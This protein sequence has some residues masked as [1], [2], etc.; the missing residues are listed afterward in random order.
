MEFFSITTK[1]YEGEVVNF[2]NKLW[3][4]RN[5]YIIGI[6]KNLFFYLI[7]LNHSALIVEEKLLD[8]FSHHLD[9]FPSRSYNSNFQN[10]NNYSDLLKQL[11]NKYDD[12]YE[13]Y[14]SKLIKISNQNDVIVTYF[15]KQ[16][17]P[18][19]ECLNWKIYNGISESYKIEQYYVNEHKKLVSKNKPKYQLDSD[20][21]NIPNFNELDLIDECNKTHKPGF[22][23]ESINNIFSF[24]DLEENLED[25]THS[26]KN[27]ELNDKRKKILIYNII[28]NKLRN[29]GLDIIVDKI[30]DFVEPTINLN[31]GDIVLS[32]I[33]GV[34]NITYNNNYLYNPFKKRVYMVITDIYL[35]IN[36]GIREYKYLCET[37]KINNFNLHSA[38]FN[39]SGIERI[40]IGNLFYFNNLKGTYLKNKNKESYIKP[41]PINKLHSEEEFNKNLKIYKLNKI[42]EMTYFK[43]LIKKIIN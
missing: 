4:V 1:F 16:L 8:K 19:I 17:N 9:I 36:N 12:L 41:T 25:N 21:Y 10:R 33:H 28:F 27:K 3:I 42:K 18:Y 11:I 14:Y 31:I 30:Y 13:S 20:A 43:T 24:L 6:N 39:F 29:R 38:F 2:E 22:Y 23:D 35:V 34:N 26:N 37:V 15:F 5:I 40:Y 32:K 7:E